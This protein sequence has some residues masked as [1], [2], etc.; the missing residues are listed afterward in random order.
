MSHTLKNLQPKAAGSFKYVR[1]LSGHQALNNQ[2][3][4]VIL[5]FR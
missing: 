5:I 2:Q 4:P 3:L 1:S